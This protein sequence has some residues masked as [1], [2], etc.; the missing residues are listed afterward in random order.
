MAG[1]LRTELLG[2]D[3]D[4]ARPLMDEL[5]RLEAVIDLGVTGPAAG[6]AADRLRALAAKLAGA[7]ADEPAGELIAEKLESATSQELF[8]FID[9]EFG[10]S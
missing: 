10:D 1:Y 6:R 5:A 3:D 9:S 4:A 7:G 8:D 2:D